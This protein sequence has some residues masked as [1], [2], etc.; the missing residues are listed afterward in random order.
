MLLQQ[1]SKY[2][3][4]AIPSKQKTNILDLSFAWEKY[5]LDEG[6]ISANLRS[7]DSVDSL[8]KGLFVQKYNNAATTFAELSKSHKDKNVVWLHF[9]PQAGNAL[10]L[11]YGNHFTI[12]PIITSIRSLARDSLSPK[13]TKT[14]N[15]SLNAS[16]SGPSA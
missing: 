13:A 4:K 11:S 3:M 5:E 1:T 14:R 15:S 6:K 12:Q 16:S 10:A 7:L 8:L 9:H 2:L